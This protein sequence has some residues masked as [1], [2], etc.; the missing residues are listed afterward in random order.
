MLQGDGRASGEVKKTRSR[1]EII[2]NL[3]THNVR[4]SWRVDTQRSGFVHP[5][6]FSLSS[7]FSHAHIKQ[8]SV[9]IIVRGHARV[10]A[11]EVKASRLD[12]HHR[13][14]N[15]S[16]LWV[17]SGAQ[18]KAG[19]TSQ[20]SDQGPSCWVTTL[21]TESRDGGR[22]GFEGKSPKVL[23]NSAGKAVRQLKLSDLC[24]SLNCRA[25]VALVSVTDRYK[26]RQLY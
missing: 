15:F 3:V 9:L 23:R 21:P 16:W 12:V 17:K 4:R 25:L 6:F 20:G 19:T 2:K 13:Q 1:R 11:R 8:P 5:P 26:D 10:G 14:K 18:Q 7:P 24:R 22:A